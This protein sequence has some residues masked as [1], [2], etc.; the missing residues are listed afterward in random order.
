MTIAVNGIY[1]KHNPTGIANVLI[2][3]VNA[4]SC[5]KD[6]KVIIYLNTEMASACAKRLDKRIEIKI[7]PM[8][9]LKTNSTL[10]FL[11]KFASIVNKENPDL[12]WCP[13]PWIP[14]G[15]KSKQK[16]MVTVHDFVSK[17]FKSTMR[18]SNSAITGL[19]ERHSVKRADFF[20]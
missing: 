14:F 16:V 7:L 11:L 10:W 15:L 3:T 17:E 20:G 19:I 9:F 2:K 13:A 5:W 6:V 12:L 1:L 4:W 8:P 18:F